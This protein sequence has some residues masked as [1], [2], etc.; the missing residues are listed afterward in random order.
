MVRL[1]KMKMHSHPIHASNQ[2]ELSVVPRVAVVTGRGLELSGAVVGVVL[3]PDGTWE[4]SLSAIRCRS[5]FL[6]YLLPCIS[7]KLA[8]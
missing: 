2:L 4:T 3:I 7:L 1:H 8:T 5:L 6:F